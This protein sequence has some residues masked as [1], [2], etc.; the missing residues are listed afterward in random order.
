[1]S[2]PGGILT[3]TARLSQ[4]AREQAEAARREQEAE[5]RRRDLVRRRESLE[6]QIEEMRAA[7]A[8]EEAE[9]NVLLTQEDAHEAALAGDRVAVAAA[10]GAA[11]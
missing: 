2:A 1:M 11:E 8:A 7:L 4:A 9:A 5:R 10:R 3:G 6:R